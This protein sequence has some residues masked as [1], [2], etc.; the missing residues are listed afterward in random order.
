MLVIFHIFDMSSARAPPY[1]YALMERTRL[2]G[3]PNTASAGPIAVSIRLSNA[4]LRVRGTADFA[5]RIHSRIRIGPESTHEGAID[6]TIRKSCF[7]ASPGINGAFPDL[8]SEGDVHCAECHSPR[9]AFGAII[10]GLRFTGGPNPTGRGFVP[11]ITQYDLKDWSVNDIA[12][13]LETGL[14]PE[15]DSVGSTMAE[16][17]RSTAQLSTEDR[18]AIATYVKSLPPVEG[19]KPQKE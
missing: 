5:R 4:R 3:A 2:R 8:V 1:C 16:V 10:P 17:V 11:N 19:M 6:A 13:L 14:T 18:I 9:N 7:R 12:Y 15:G